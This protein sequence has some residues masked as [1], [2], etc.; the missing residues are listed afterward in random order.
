M[1]RMEIHFE[2]ENP[3]EAEAFCETAKTYPNISEWRCDQDDY[4]VIITVVQRDDIGKVLFELWQL[5]K[6]GEAIGSHS[7]VTKK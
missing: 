5:H 4:T 7:C 3:A 2:F 6:H 1:E